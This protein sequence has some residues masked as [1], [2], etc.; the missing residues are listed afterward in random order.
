MYCGCFNLYYGCFNLFCN[1]WG[2]VICVLVVQGVSFP[3]SP[4]SPQTTF[5][6]TMETC[7]YLR[8]VGRI[9]CTIPWER[10]PHNITT[11][12]NV[13]HSTQF[14]SKNNKCNT[15]SVFHDRDMICTAIN[16]HTDERVYKSFSSP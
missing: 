10:S 4:S 16:G 15:S 8:K 11:P 12:H 13:T 1:V 6:L 7:R 2:C 3:P 9:N 14:V 5:T